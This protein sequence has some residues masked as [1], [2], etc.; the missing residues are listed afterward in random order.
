MHRTLKKCDNFDGDDDRFGFDGD[1]DS[2][3][4]NRLVDVDRPNG[5]I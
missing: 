3:D 2:F 1:D 4:S 5:G